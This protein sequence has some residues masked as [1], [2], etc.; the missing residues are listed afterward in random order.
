M[1]GAAA[2]RRLLSETGF[3][4]VSLRTLPHDPLNAYYIARKA[5]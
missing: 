5:G 4:D 3:A 1:W 2:A